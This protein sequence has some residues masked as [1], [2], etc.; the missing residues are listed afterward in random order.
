VSI[1][2]IA[3]GLHAANVAMGIAAAARG[4]SFGAAHHAMYAIVFAA[5]LAATLFAFHPALLVTVGTLA[6]LSRVRARSKWHPALAAVGAAG[7]IVV[8]AAGE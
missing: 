2:V 5:A 4:V 3:A 1:V 6:A 7:Y 8:L